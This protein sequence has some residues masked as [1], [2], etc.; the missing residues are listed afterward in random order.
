MV[1]ITSVV[2]E[3]LVDEVCLTVTVSPLL[4]KP[5]VPVK[6]ARPLIEYSPPVMLISASVSIPEI[7]IVFEVI[8]VFR[9]TSVW[10]LNTKV[11]GVESPPLDDELLLEL[12]EELLLEL[13]ELL[14]L[15]E[16][17]LLELLE[18]LELDDELEL[19]VPPEL[20]EELLE[21]LVELE[22][23]ELELEDELELL[24]EELL[25]EPPPPPPQADRANGRTSIQITVVILRLNSANL[26]CMVVTL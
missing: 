10:S 14:E 6:E 2:V 3:K 25:P 7:V 13:L 8:D 11:F 5:G 23:D 15:A 12:D 9:S 24:L 17:L 16:V 26:V 18:L 21:L 4:T 1:S 20:V 22:D 19:L